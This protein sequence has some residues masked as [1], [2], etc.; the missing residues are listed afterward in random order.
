M[1]AVQPKWHRSI[2]LDA[3]YPPDVACAL[4]GRETLLDENHL[5]AACRLSLIPAP[6][7]VCPAPLSGITAA[8]RYIGGARE[9]IRALKYHSQ[10]RLAPF[11]AGAI[12]LPPEWEID[13][14]VPVPLHPFKQWLR[15]YNQSALLAEELCRRYRLTQQNNLLRRTRFTRSQTTLSELERAKNVAKAFQASSEG[16]GC[17]ILLVDDVTTTHST[18][19]SC[20]VA[21]RAA[22]AVNIYAACAAA[23]FT[24]RGELEDGETAE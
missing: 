22:G 10:V 13:R 20:A 18:L 6:V 16:K 3:L 9:G 2:L 1:S 11:F 5:C 8:Y 24:N 17:N 12:V 4:C 19:L 7:L 23:A 15:S 21:L 14:V